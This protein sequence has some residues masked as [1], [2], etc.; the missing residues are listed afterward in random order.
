MV[1]GR[2]TASDTVL[3]PV[4]EIYVYGRSNTRARVQATV[5]TGFTEYFTLPL[6]AIRELDLPWRL[7]LLHTFAPDG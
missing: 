4:V 7:C 1:T 6:H 5:D 2:V 3:Q